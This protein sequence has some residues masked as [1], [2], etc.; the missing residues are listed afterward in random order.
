V[1]ASFTKVVSL[2]AVNRTSAVVFFMT[3]V[4]VQASVRY[5]AGNL[6][7]TVSDA[8]PVTRH[9][10]T[11]SGLSPD[12]AY[13]YAVAAGTASQSGSFTTSFDAA[14]AAPK[15]FSFAVVGDA[16]AHAEWATVAR[17]VLAK[18]PRF[19]IQTGD[20]NDA[21]GS[22]T[23]WADYYNV[24]RDLFASVPV[25]AAEGNHDVGSNYSVYNVAPQSSSGSD[26]YYA[27]AWGNAAFVAIDTNGNTSPG[28]AQASWLSGVLPKLSG[29][30]LF[31]FHHHPLYSCGAHGSSTALQGN[32]Q[33]LFEG[34]RLT[35]DFTGHD[36]DLIAWSTVNGVRYVVSG[37]GG[38]SLYGLA[39][40]Q[41]PFAQQ[42]YGFMMVD[43]N[44]ATIN[45][46]FYDDAGNALWSSGTFQAAGASVDPTKLGGVVVY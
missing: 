12:T 19:M 32:L 26:V 22:A 21:N 39:G 16:R 30:P 18:K 15:A 29:G 7:S 31:A 13:Q 35:S 5:G 11:L 23:N 1:P 45:Q 24:A 28:S 40:C 46:T 27:F 20:N 42:T 8:A 6:G 14:P 3:D 41:G 38:T 4:A 33:A 43:V 34:N 25:F 9:V 36:H 37:G 2:H 10:L 17:S 44:G